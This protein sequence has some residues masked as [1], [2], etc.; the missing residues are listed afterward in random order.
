MREQPLGQTHKAVAETEV[1]SVF[2]STGLAS[3][4]LDCWMETLVSNDGQAGSDHFVRNL[5]C[6]YLYSRAWIVCSA[7]S[8]TLQMC[9]L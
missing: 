4:S 9:D 5:T 3:A 1:F 6:F 8:V 7:V 2:L